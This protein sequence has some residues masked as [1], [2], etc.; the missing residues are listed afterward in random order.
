L[1]SSISLGLAEVAQTLMA[2]PA[3]ILGARRFGWGLARTVFM[4]VHVP[5]SVILR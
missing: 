5:F 1:A 2:A 4:F 3:Y